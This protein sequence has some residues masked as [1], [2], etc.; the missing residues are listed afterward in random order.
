VHQHQRCVNGQAIAVEVAGVGS[1]RGLLDR[2]REIGV[3]D[4][5]GRRLDTEALAT[6]GVERAQGAGD[7][8]RV[9]LAEEQRGAL[10]A[11]RDDVGA[12]AAGGDQLAQDP[13][14]SPRGRAASAA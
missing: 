6:G 11:E 10:G 14:G 2:E 7:L 4:E 12:V 5:R 8:D 1:E 13:S 9:L 3:R